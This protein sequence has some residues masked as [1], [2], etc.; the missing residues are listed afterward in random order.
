MGT[1]CSRAGTLTTN[2]YPESSNQ[3]PAFPNVESAAELL[4]HLSV[5]GFS[6]LSN[7]DQHEKMEEIHKKI[8]QCGVIEQLPEESEEDFRL[9][10]F[11]EMFKKL[12]FPEQNLFLSR[13][14]NK[15]KRE[16]QFGELIS[17]FKQ[18][19]TNDQQEK[20]GKFVHVTA[21]ETNE[22]LRLCRFTQIARDYTDYV[23]E[24]LFGRWWYIKK[25]KD[26]DKSPEWLLVKSR[27]SEFFSGF[28]IIWFRGQCA[29]DQ[30]GLIEELSRRIKDVKIKKFFEPNQHLRL[31]RFTE[32]S[33]KVVHFRIQVEFLDKAEKKLRQWTY[34][35]HRLFLEPQD[36][37]S[38]AELLSR[39][40][41]FGFGLLT[42]NDQL[43]NI[44]KCSRNFTVRN[45]IIER[46]EEQ[47]GFNDQ[48]ELMEELMEELSGLLWEYKK[49]AIKDIIIKKFSEESEEDF[50]LR[51]FIRLC[52]VNPSLRDLFIR[53]EAEKWDLNGMLQTSVYEGI[54]HEIEQHSRYAEFFF[55]VSIIWF[56]TRCA[57]DPRNPI[58]LLLSGDIVEKLPNESEEDFRLRRFIESFKKLPFVSQEYLVNYIHETIFHD[59]G[60]VES[61]CGAGRPPERSSFDL[62]FIKVKAPNLKGVGGET[63]QAVGGAATRGGEATTGGAPVTSFSS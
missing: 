27:F 34:L 37:A 24:R 58:Q 8:A 38:A 23:Y 9:R 11:T 15:F 45:V 33:K 6:Q 48:Q 5:F 29:N 43:E 17:W 28:S 60:P 63:T 56:K 59:L 3:K 22:D 36:S 26:N 2:S 31:K 7:N 61:V 10:K 19:D 4:L 35:P 16:R 57:S 46:L 49:E 41:S 47:L 21:E 54:V 62:E 12:T 53:S 32:L 30:R 14:I 25:R 55:G 40:S 42:L 52:C 51:K 13:V 1:T 18:L 50:R 39:L 44:E 20:L